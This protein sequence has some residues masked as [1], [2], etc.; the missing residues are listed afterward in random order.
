MTELQLHATSPRPTAL[1]R[2]IVALLCV[3]AVGL[4]L[5]YWAFFGP[6]ASPNITTPDLTHHMLAAA[7]QQ[8]H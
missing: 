6:S 5:I 4:A 7:P 8:S 2:E 1:R 3:K